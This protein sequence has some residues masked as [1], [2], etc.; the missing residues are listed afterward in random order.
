MDQQLCL[1][2]RNNVSSLVFHRNCPKPGLQLGDGYA[3]LA[4]EV[5]PLHCV[6][7]SNLR[8]SKTR[9][10]N[11]KGKVLVEPAMGKPTVI[12]LDVLAFYDIFLEPGS[13]NLIPKALAG[14]K[15]GTS[16]LQEDSLRFD[17]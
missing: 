13:A 5:V 7:L 11:Q 10:R 6:G 2:V 15:S 8:H 17:K 12:V 9:L 16:C 3:R 14:I 1:A 4:G